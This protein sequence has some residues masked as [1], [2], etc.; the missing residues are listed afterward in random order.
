[1]KTRANKNKKEIVLARVRAY[2]DDFELSVGSGGTFSRDE[3]I[4]NIEKETEIGQEIVEMQ[5]EYLRDLI[6]GDIYKIL[7]N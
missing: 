3:I 2:D 5:M 7:E 1:M 4:E 6:S